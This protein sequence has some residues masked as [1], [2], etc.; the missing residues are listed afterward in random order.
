[1]NNKNKLPFSSYFIE[2][3][4]CQMNIS[5]SEL[6]AASL[7]KEG[8]VK[9]DMIDA[10]VV[11]FNTCSVRKHAEDRAV[12]RLRE[13]K[14]HKRKRGI[15]IAAGCLSQHIGT[16]LLEDKICDIAV[17]P[18]ESP[19]I[20]QIIREFLKDNSRNLF[21][22][23]EKDDFAGRL[24]P[25]LIMRPEREH[26]HRFVT[27]THGCENF[28]TYC[29]VPHV[30]GPLISFN[31]EEIIDFIKQL[32]RSGVFEV[33]L[34]GQNVNQFGQDN[35]D[36][37]FCQL[38][39]RVSTIPGIEKINFMTSHPK[40]FNPDIIR[41]IANNNTIARS[42]HLPLQSGSDEIL[43]RMNR[44]YNVKH[45]IELID[46]IRQAGDIA[47][48]TDLIVGFPG[49][50]EEQHKESMALIKEIGY[51]DAYMYAYS[52]REGT[53]SAK[54]DMQLSKETKN[55]RLTELI[56]MQREITVSRLDN[57]IG[58]K[59]KIVVERV[60]RKNDNEVSG[61]TFSNRQAVLAGSR[62]D[63]GKIFTIEYEKVNGA[64]L[65][66]KKV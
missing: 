57:L 25:S 46:S 28:C 39:E 61:K 36:I 58:K 30:R 24:H 53:V 34:L 13:A 12:A 40:D 64:T 42:I 21:I 48:T 49:E 62:D 5:D 8:L 66:G 47:I 43:K 1:M 19:N 60:S 45:Y 33:T 22:S 38:L 7:E 23:S 10:D 14:A 65:Y 55:R 31:S 35:G 32:P 20:A 11:V 27:I 63:I 16:R 51:D 52:P 15:V 2:T 3:F 54:Y 18:Y 44:G 4:G 50:T 26:W 56:T 41:Q 6:I 37:S 9:M 59:E 17:G 29:I